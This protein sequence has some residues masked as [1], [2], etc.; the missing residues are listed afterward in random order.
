MSVAVGSLTVIPDPEDVSDSEIE[1]GLPAG[2][3]AGVQGIQVVHQVPLG[4]PSQ[5]HR[6]PASNLAAFVLQPSIS[7]ISLTNSTGTGDTPRSAN[8]QLAVTPTVG[9][10]QRVVLLLNQIGTTT[11]RAYS[12]VAPERN[13]DSGTLTIPITGV[14][15]GNYLVR[16]QVDG[17]ESPLALDSDPTS[18]TFNQYIVPGLSIP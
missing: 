17:A 6:G 11:P 1:L 5:P 10:R 7:S 4:L 13:A 15:A 16:V 18:P 12:F 2:L 8:V 3:Q 9:R 14:T